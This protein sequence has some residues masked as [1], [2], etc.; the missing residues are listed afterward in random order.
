M[1][2]RTVRIM[3]VAGAHDILYIEG[4]VDGYSSRV[5]VMRA[6]LAELPDLAARRLYVGQ[7]LVRAAEARR[8]EQ[9]GAL[10][11]EVVVP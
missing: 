8:Q 7:A 1:A 11:G 4:S 2:T 3:G 5:T 6:V 10:I 9:Y